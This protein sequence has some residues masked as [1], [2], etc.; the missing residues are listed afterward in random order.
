M[1]TKIPKWIV[2]IAL[3]WGKGTLVYR[4]IYFPF[5]F[6]A[7]VSLMYVLCYLHKEICSKLKFPIIHFILE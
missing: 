3:Q 7:S 4:E 1:I 2:M 6:V 5:S